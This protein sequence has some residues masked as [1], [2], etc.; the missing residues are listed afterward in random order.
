[1]ANYNYIKENYRAFSEM[2]NEAVDNYQVGKWTDKEERDGFKIY[3]LSDYILFL[4][5][6]NY[7]NIQ[8]NNPLYKQYQFSK[9]LFI[10]CDR[11]KAGGFNNAIPVEGVKPFIELLGEHI[12]EFVDK[13][14]TSELK[15]QEKIHYTNMAFAFRDEPNASQQ[16]A[17][18]T[19]QLKQD[20]LLQIKNKVNLG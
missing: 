15:K 19:A 2:L 7:L 20:A 14:L 4:Y 17:G 11:Y 1:M 10:L 5:E 9:K 8:A 13:D 12:K 3:L 16:L 6:M 18:R